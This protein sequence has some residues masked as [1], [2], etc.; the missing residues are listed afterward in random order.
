MGDSLTLPDASTSVIAARHVEPPP[1]MAEHV[2]QI[3]RDDILRGRLRPGQRLIETE[4]AERTRVSRTPVREGLRLLESEGLVVS[5]RSRGFQVATQLSPEDTLV[6]YD[7]RLV[8]EP[9]L[10]TKAVEEGTTDQFDEV[11]S[12]L[13]RF[14]NRSSSADLLELSALDAGF[15]RAVYACSASTLASLFDVYWSQMHAFLTKVI[16]GAESPEHFQAEHVEIFEAMKARKAG[17]AAKLMRAHI[18]HGRQILEG[19]ASARGPASLAPENRERER[20]NPEKR[21]IESGGGSLGA[22]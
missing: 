22:M 21:R 12:A 5:R 16:Y 14:S 3:L 6:L 7:A 20:Q 11:R 4:V 19:G 13:D 18:E 17:L 15:H 10:T 2:R 1:S 8:I 9:Y